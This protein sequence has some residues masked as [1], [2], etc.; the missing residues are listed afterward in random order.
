MV[1]YGSSSG[2]R[3]CRP[4]PCASPPPL[5]SCLTVPPARRH[6]AR[7]CL[8][9]AARLGS[10]TRLAAGS[11]L[12]LWPPCASCQTCGWRPD[13]PSLPKD[14]FSPSYLLCDFGFQ[15]LFHL[16]T[17]ACC[18]LFMYGEVMDVG[19]WSSMMSGVGGELLPWWCRR[20]CCA[21]RYYYPP[22]YLLLPP[23]LSNKMYSA[24]S[25]H[26]RSRFP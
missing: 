20:R 4:C 11:R 19:C 1:R 9:R 16:F 14:L 26:R 21:L 15:C 6:S 23:S 8:A 3:R 24:S 5:L 18:L 22:L 25:K 10:R 2:R 12:G 7:P 13:V 17:D